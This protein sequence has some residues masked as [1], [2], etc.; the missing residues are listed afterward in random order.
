MILPE[1]PE[2]LVTILKDQLIPKMNERE[3]EA[4]EAYFSLDEKK[5]NN[6]K[7]SQEFI[8]KMILKYLETNPQ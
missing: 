6:F 8:K 4:L 3:I 5:Q 1:D 7:T 2:E